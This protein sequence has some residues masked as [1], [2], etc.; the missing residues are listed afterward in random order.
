M[1]STSVLQ[2]AARLQPLVVDLDG[3]LLRTDLLL[4]SA[5]AY[6]RAQPLHFIR[7]LLWLAR[8][9]KAGLKQRLAESAQLDLRTLPYDPSVIALIRQARQEGR[10]VILATASHCT[11]AHRIAASLELF[12]EVLASDGIINLS[13]ENKRSALVARFGEGGFDYAGN[14]RDDLPVWQ[15]AHEAIAVNPQPGVSARLATRSGPTRLLLTTRATAADW[16]NALRLH[17]WLKNLLLFVPLLAAHR[18][19]EPGL[20]AAGLLAFIAF[21]LCASSVYV[22]NDL[23]DLSA[24]RQ[25]PS[26]RERAF[27]SGRLPLL[28]GLLLIPLLLAAAFTLAASALPG[29]FLAALGA[30]YLL[31]LAYSLRLKRYMMVDVIALALLYTLRIVAGAAAMGIALSFW[32]LAFS[33]FMFLSLALVKRHSELT[34]TQALEPPPDLGRGYVPSD[35]AT[36]ASLGGSAGFMAVLVLALYINDLNAGAAY[37]HP[38]LIWLACPLL[39]YWVGRTWLLTRRGEMHDDP[40]VFAMRDRTSLV[41]GALFGLVFW[42]A[43]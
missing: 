22:L 12:D 28:T 42:A 26:K 37:S 38:Q 16:M 20:L 39:L 36:I 10:Q 13:A 35:L 9:G 30:Y 3:T 19:S 6:L 25:H 17:Q 4:E 40:V 27:A 11:L 34:S 18:L 32:I 31:T 33:M 14:A 43:I 2:K 1:T 15:S 29:A 23:L 21:G 7:P 41:V 8:H 5:L 24:D